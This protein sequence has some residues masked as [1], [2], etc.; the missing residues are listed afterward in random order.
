MEDKTVHAIYFSPAQSTKKIVEAVAQGISNNVICHNITLGIQE[1]IDFKPNDR[2]VIGVPSYVGRV[3]ALA[4]KYLS[5]IKAN[6]TYAILVCVYGNR[7]YQDTLLELSHISRDSGFIPICS[8]AFVARH[9]IFPDVASERPDQ[10]DL[11][12]AAQ[13]GRQSLEYIKGEKSLVLDLP[14][15]YP[16]IEAKK[17]PLVPKTN[18]NCNQCGICVKNCPVGAIDPNNP[19]K[20]DKKMC[21]ACTR[22]IYVC[23]Q[24]A[25]QFKG[26]KYN[27]V[28]RQFIK[29]NS[30]RKEIEWFFPE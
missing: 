30:E 15:D 13:F 19:E 26:I 24:N 7:E 12:K 1:S 22:C 9:S 27:L 2:V 25:R 20:T 6:G 5:K 14:G 3:P 4:A 10:S 29:N 17:V 21:I 11:E 28:R 18:S 23:P 8:G 16:Y